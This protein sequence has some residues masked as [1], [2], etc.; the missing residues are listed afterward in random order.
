VD[1]LGLRWSGPWPQFID[2]PQDFP[3]QGSRHGNLGQIEATLRL[4]RDYGAVVSVLPATRRDGVGVREGNDYCKSLPREQVILT[5]TP[6]AYRRDILLDAVRQ[7]EAQGWQEISPAALVAK[8]GYAVRLLESPTANLK[9]TYPGD[10]EKAHG[11]FVKDLAGNHKPEP[12][13]GS[14][15]PD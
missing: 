1:F 4:V 10:L 11:Q 9:I 8:A 13:S 14:A 2:P 15:L 7:A 5:Q 3:K 6:Q 12:P